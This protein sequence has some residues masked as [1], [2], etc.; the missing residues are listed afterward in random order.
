[1]EPRIEMRGGPLLPLPQLQSVNGHPVGGDAAGCRAG[2]LR[3]VLGSAAVAPE[4]GRMRPVVFL[5]LVLSERPAC[6]E[7][8]GS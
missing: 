7:A 2:E 8:G 6:E 5:L 3:M 4:G 1:M